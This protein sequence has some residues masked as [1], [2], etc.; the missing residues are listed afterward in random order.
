MFKNTWSVYN[1]FLRDTYINAENSPLNS[2]SEILTQPTYYPSNQ[3]T[4]HMIWSVCICKSDQLNLHFLLEHTT[5]V[6][7]IEKR[8]YLS[9]TSETSS[10]EVTP[11]MWK[12]K[13]TT[14]KNAVKKVEEESLQM[15]EQRMND[16][17][18]IE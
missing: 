18:D 2:S 17:S 10:A 16:L 3:P 12:N 6:H 14:Q 9:Q 13:D 15:T 1:V 4:N 5:V 7:L 11:R 8:D